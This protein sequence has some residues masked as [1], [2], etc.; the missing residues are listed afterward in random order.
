ME[1]SLRKGAGGVS[2]GEGSRCTG[3]KE[4]EVQGIKVGVGRDMA[5]PPNVLSACLRRAQRG[6]S[7]WQPLDSRAESKQ[8]QS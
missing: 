2:A 6:T 8:R 3:G 4:Q 1:A 7:V 5:P